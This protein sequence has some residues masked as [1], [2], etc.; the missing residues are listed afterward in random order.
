V[1][2]RTSG[3]TY[4]PGN[5]IFE[6][7]EP[8]GSAQIGKAPVEL[9]YEAAKRN[10][11]DF[12]NI[13]QDYPSTTPMF[14]EEENKYKEMFDVVN[15]KVETNIKTSDEFA[16]NILKQIA[17]PDNYGTANSKLMQLKFLYEMTKLTEKKTEK[18]ITDLFFLAEKRGPGF[19]PFGKLY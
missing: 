3:R 11:M 17:D 4:R 15:K 10:K 1:T 18:F 14:V 16:R 5:L 12:K 9:V 6:F 13:W 7:Q 19:G 2:I 8:G